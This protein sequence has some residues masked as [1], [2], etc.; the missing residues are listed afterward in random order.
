MAKVKTSF[1]C[2]E[3][4]YESAR[5]YGK[6]PQCGSWNAMSEVEIAPRQEEAKRNRHAGD[7]AAQA[8]LIGDI[9]EEAAQRLSSGIGELDRVLGGG[10]VEGA[11]M[12]VG[13]DPGIGKS[14]LLTQASANMARAGIPVLYASGEESARQ[15]KLR[16][17]RLGAEAA[18]F[19]VLAENDMEAVLHAAQKLGAR[20]LVIDSIQT[21]LLPGIA[22]TPGSVTQVRETATALIRYAKQNGC[23]AFLVG[24]VTKEGSLA[25]PRVLEHMVDVVLYFE[26]DR[27]HQYRMLRAV[28]NRYGSSNELGMFEMAGDGMREVKNASEMLLSERAADASGSVVMC[29]MEGTRPMLTDVQA[30]VT[31]TVFG[32][33][34]RMASGVDQ[35]RLALLLAVLEKRAGFRLYDQDVYINIAGGMT[36]TEPAADLALVLAVASSHRDKPIDAKTLAIGEVGLTGEVRS[37]TAMQQ[38]LTEAARLGFTRCIVPRHSTSQ[39]TVPDGMELIRVRNIREAIEMAL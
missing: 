30:L 37:V 31:T 19:Y 9:P 4:G 15:I 11:V 27:Q 38:R 29:A 28:K 10:A 1:V 6:C 17:R 13:G 36:L 35:G 8:Y 12:L 3:C 26:G 33:P 22:S 5:W 25:G 16:A 21:M 2:G 34:R 20:M 23:G 7:G 32:N 18:G 24:H 39:L 14:T